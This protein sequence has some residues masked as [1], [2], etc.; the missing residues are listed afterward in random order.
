[1]KRIRK[2]CVL[3]AG[4]MR[5]DIARICAQAGLEVAIRDIEQRFVDGGINTIK[6]NLNREVKKGK[7]TR[8]EADA[9]LARI[10]PTQDLREAEIGRAHV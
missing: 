1:M 6:K 7:K 8:E 3:G 9:I 4:L 2:V 5:N 10:K